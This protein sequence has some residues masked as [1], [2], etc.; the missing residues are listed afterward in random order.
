MV[1]CFDNDDLDEQDS[2]DYYVGDNGP[3]SIPPINGSAS[4]NENSGKKLLTAEEKEIRAKK[5]AA[6]AKKKAKQLEQIKQQQQ[7]QVYSDEAGAGETAGDTLGWDWANDARS[8]AQFGAENSEPENYDDDF[9]D[10][11]DKPRAHPPIN[12]NKPKQSKTPSQ[13]KQKLALPAL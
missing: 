9:D 8:D 7:N 3:N 2:Y 6:K 1:P 10:E 5:K 13:R 4:N 11:D 12:S